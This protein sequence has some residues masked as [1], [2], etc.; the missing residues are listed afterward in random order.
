MLIQGCAVI[1]QGRYINHQALR[2]LGA[3]ERITSVTSFRPKSPLM[4]DDTVLTTIRPVSDLN[5]L[6][7][8]FGTYRLEILEER[9][10]AQLKAVRD[11]RHAGKLFPTADFKKFLKLQEAFFAHTNSEMIPA[12]EVTAGQIIDTGVPEEPDKAE[13]QASKRSRSE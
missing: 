11:M 9:I 3:Q 6:Y 5:E 4:A 13:E 8:D 12:E 2:A 7:Y 1:L 10:R